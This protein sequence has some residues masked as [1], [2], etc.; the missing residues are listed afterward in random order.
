MIFPDGN[1]GGDYSRLSG[2]KRVSPA[3]MLL[4]IFSWYFFWYFFLYFF[5]A[6]QANEYHNGT[7]GKAFHFVKSFAFTRSTFSKIVAAADLPRFRCKSGGL[8]LEATG[9]HGR[10]RPAP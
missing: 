6:S 7:N 8:P 4:P 3:P 9:Q 2:Y 10:H 5:L 1:A